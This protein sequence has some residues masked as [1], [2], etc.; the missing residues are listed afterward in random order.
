MSLAEEYDFSR[1]KCYH[2]TQ[3]VD[4]NTG[5]LL[6]V[7]CNKCLPCLRRR[8]SEWIVRLKEQI[9]QSA[10]DSCYFVTLTYNDEFV[11]ILVD[12][13]H[14]YEDMMNLDKRDFLR[15]FRRMRSLVDKGGFIWHDS[16]GELP[17]TPVNVERTHFKYYCTTEYGPVG[18][19][20]HAHIIFFDLDPDKWK[21]ELLV[22]KCWQYGFISVFPASEDDP[23]F[24][25]YVTKYLVNNLLSPNPRLTKPFSLMSKGLGL[26][27]IDRMA[28]WHGQDL[29]RRY[30]ALSGGS[31]DVL[32]RYWR[33]AIYSPSQRMVQADTI[34]KNLDREAA[35]ISSRIHSDEELVR[36]NKARERFIK[37]TEYANLQV[38]LKKHKIK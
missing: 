26:A 10:P 14:V 17:D 2:P 35:M 37:N 19:R 31:K 28:E 30:S 33:D 1:L 16:H 7:P 11:P 6:M 15:F 12:R 27:Y 32:P 8:Q 18:K 3:I 24:I 20:P 25:G 38:M 36:F 21:V 22:E 23:G 13:G 9:S 5:E 4:K 29:N 34:R